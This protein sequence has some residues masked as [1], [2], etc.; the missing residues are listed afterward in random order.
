MT[1]EDQTGKV[2]QEPGGRR[3]TRFGVVHHGVTLMLL[4]TF[5]TGVVDAVGYLALDRVFTGNMTGNV[6]ILA[7]ALGGADDLPVLGP[8]T[9]LATF[10]LGAMIAGS[11]LRRRPA[12][13][14]ATI[15]VLLLTGAA[16][17]AGVGVLLH[18]LPHTDA[19]RVIAAAGTAAV[20]GVQATVA[21]KV[22]VTD[23]TTVVVTSTLTSWASETL[24]AGGLGALW[25]RRAGALLTILA[26]ALAGALL[27]RLGALVPMLL[28]AALT[29]VVGVT[30]HVF[31]GRRGGKLRREG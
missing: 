20:M 13:W 21:R 23:M 12:G 3:G 27:L 7:M 8:F 18:V 16:L 26:G 29:A 28:A 19:V 5:V 9:A 1:A 31:M 24:V 30:G 11:I 10:T 6:V 2:L 17:L 25:N 14:S 4:L 22:A 15:T